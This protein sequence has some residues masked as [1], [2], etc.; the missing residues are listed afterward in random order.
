MEFFDLDQIDKNKYFREAE[1]YLKDANLECFKIDRDRFA[2][3]Y[4]D[5]LIK[6]Y[7]VPFYK[8]TVSKEQLL[9]AKANPQI[10]ITNDRYTPRK[11]GE[12]EMTREN[13]HML[14]LAHAEDMLLW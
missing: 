2:F 4:N 9:R 13:G 1:K 14:L 3:M 11:R 8:K 10:V 6:I 7:F 12:P 5:G